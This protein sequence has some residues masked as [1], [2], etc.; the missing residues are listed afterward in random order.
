MVHN[1][2]VALNVHVDWAVL[3]VHIANAFNIVFLMIIFQNL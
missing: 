3:Q 2:R 1:L